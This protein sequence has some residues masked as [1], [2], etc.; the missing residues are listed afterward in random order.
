MNRKEY[1]FYAY[2]LHMVKE[3]EIL[4]LNRDPINNSASCSKLIKKVIRELGQ[5]DREN[6]VVVMLNTLNSKRSAPTWYLLGVLMGVW[7]IR[8]RS[9]KPR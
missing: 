4:F 9:L 6:F 8:G 7:Y 1:R 3:K 5:T 2:K